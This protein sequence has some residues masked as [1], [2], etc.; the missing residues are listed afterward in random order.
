M[1]VNQ[2]SFMKRYL[3]WMC[4]ER[5]TN[6]WSYIRYEGGGEEMFQSSTIDVIGKKKAPSNCTWIILRIYFDGCT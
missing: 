2:N 1:D 5:L 3:F 6:S 4:R